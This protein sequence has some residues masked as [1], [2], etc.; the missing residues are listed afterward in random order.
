MVESG[1]SMRLRNGGVG[2]LS[3]SRLWRS[4]C[5]QCSRAVAESEYSVVLG[6]VWVALLN[7]QCVWVKVEAKYSMPL[8]YG[9]VGVVNALGSFLGR[10]AQCVWVLVESEY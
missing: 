1:Y 10:S 4:G 9:K 2:V 5:T 3:P 8:G 6:H 7:A